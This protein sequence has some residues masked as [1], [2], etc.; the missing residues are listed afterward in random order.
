MDKQSFE[1]FYKTLSTSLKMLLAATLLTGIIYPVFIMYISSWILPEKASGSLIYHENL[2][3]GSKLIGQ[4][5]SSERYFSGRPSFSDYATL[6]AAAS[7]FG[8]TSASLKTAVLERMKKWGPDAPADL[9]YTSGS[10]LDPHLTLK[11]VLLQFDKVV[12]A[13][14]LNPEK[15]EKLQAFIDSAS[16]P[17]FFR[18]SN[19][20]IINILELNLAL[21]K[22]DQHESARN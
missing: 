12:K 21:D 22:I 11:S 1:P 15:K 17:N 6:P 19:T 14:N 7:N 9:L 2:P 10:G 13:R 16:A 5:F 3:K 20:N 8:P 4:S 18:T